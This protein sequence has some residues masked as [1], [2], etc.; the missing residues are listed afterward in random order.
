[1]K[2][3]KV[4]IEPNSAQRKVIDHMIDANRLVYNGLVV[5][6]KQVFG[7]ERKLPS[8][9]DLNKVTTRMRHKSPYVEDSYSTTLNETAKRVHN[10]C[11]ETLDRH[12][13]M[14]E[15]LI[16]DPFIWKLCEDH[17]PRF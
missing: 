4:R 7:K 12:R 13:V 8:I 16:L 11:K 6:C 1:M 14:H 15:E 10:A 17:F 3:L 9:F 2:T 5:A